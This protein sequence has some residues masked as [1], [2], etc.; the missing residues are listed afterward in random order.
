MSAQ[1]PARSS[2]KTAGIRRLDFHPGPVHEEQAE[3][4]AETQEA[5]EAEI[6]AERA[7]AHAEVADDE[8]RGVVRQKS[9]EKRSRDVAAIQRV[10]RQQVEDAQKYVRVGEVGEDACGVAG[11]VG[12]FGSQP[13]P[14]AP[15]DGEIC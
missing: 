9:G 1:L 12:D 11:R 10:A 15:G 6:E 3:E 4:D 7:D 14:E 5:D 2:S 13:L 8:A